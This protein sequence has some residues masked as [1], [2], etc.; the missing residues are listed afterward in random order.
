MRQTAGTITMAEPRALPAP[1]LA[2]L[3]AGYYGA[4]M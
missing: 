1:A 2:A 3:S 4:V